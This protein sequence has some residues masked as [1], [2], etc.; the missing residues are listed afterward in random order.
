VRAVAFAPSFTKA[1]PPS[2]R[3]VIYAA[4]AGNLLVALTKF[5]AAA[6]THS[7]SMLSEGVHSVVDTGNELLLL[8]GLHRA[9]EDPDRDHPLGHGR[10]LY[11]WS[12]VVAL[13]VFVLGACASFYE[14]I[15]HILKP[16]PL[17]HGSVNY[18]VLAL[19]ALF[20]GSSWWI[21][22]RSF[23]KKR[24]SEVVQAVHDSKDPPAF[25]VLFE[26]T[27]ALIGLLIAFAGVYCSVAWHSP[28]V[29]GIG[30]ILIGLVLAV[31]AALLLRE[32]KGLL[33]GERADERLVDAILKLAEDVAGV[34]HAA[35]V[36]TVHLGPREILVALNLEFADE[37]RTPEIEA[38]VAELEKRVRTDHPAVIAIFVKPQASKRILSPGVKATEASEAQGANEERVSARLRRVNSS[39]EEP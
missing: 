3:A 27:A 15:A 1:A 21:A 11:F 30:S 8:Y 18:V 10:E 6:W 9:A 31:T 33:I 38:K 5:G 14:G 36:F 34:V 7:S 37:L 12:F 39:N 26:D 28:I 2:S 19:S 17:R 13:L 20:E 29:D 16:E 24:L 32:T 4:L 35:G 22:L 25:I 23:K